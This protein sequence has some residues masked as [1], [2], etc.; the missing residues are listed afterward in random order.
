MF[1]NH[2][3]I[4]WRSLLKN[5]ITGFINI[6]GLAIGMAVAMMIGL[7]LHDELTFDQY[8]ENYEKLGQV[9]LHQEFNES[10]VTGQAASMPWGASLRN[11]FTEDFEN[12]SM[13]SWLWEHL[14]VHGENRFLKEGHYV[15]PEFPEM[16]SL[17][18]LAGNRKDALQEPKS[19]ILSKSLSVA[20]FGE[21]DPMGKM[22]K[23]DNSIDSWGNHSFQLFV[24]LKENANFADVTEKIR[25]LER[26]H[27]PVGN[28]EAMIHPIADWHL[29]SEFKEGV[30]IGGRIQF[31][32][33]FGIIGVFVLLLACINF[34]NLSTARSEKRSKE[35]GVRKAIGSLRSQLIAQF[36]SESLMVSGLALTLALVLVQGSMTAFNNLADKELAI[37]MTNV[38]FWLLVFG[39]TIFTGFLAGSYPAFYLSSFKPINT[40]KG[41]F[42]VGKWASAPRKVLVTLQFVVSIALIIGT[43]VVFQQIEYAK[44]R[45]IGYERDSLIQFFN[46]RELHDQRAIIR[47]EM[48]KTGVVEEL[49]H[50]SGPITNIWSNQSS[51]EW[52]GKDPNVELSFGVVGVSH[53]FGE[54]IQWDILE[55]RDFSREFA[56]DSMSIILNESAVALMDLDNPAGKNVRWNDRNCQVVGVVKDM[57]MESPYE[58]IKPTIFGV[59]NNRISI[60]T[61]RLKPGVPV[62]TALAKIREV[63]ANLCPTN[64]FDYEFVDAAFDEKFRSEERIGQLARIFAFLAIFISCLGLFGLSAFVAEQ[65]TK[66]IGIRK[67]LGASVMNLW[68]LQSKSFLVLVFLSCF[69]AIPLAWYYLENWLADYEYRIE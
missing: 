44:N 18:M 31:L 16:F 11:D 3:K 49:A 37:P 60:F 20:L 59:D 54:T 4:A 6:V 51:V 15:E 42:K 41:T 2:L 61:A 69:V 55:G 64:P 21:E 7:W 66:E 29:K 23:F 9:L 39:F 12:I 32:W 24:Q 19:I 45:S 25:Y 22:V 48:I 43:I 53:E 10:I 33:L 40:L 30:N 13:C 38:T 8:H 1:Q 67:V 57:I 63:Y 36:L 35:V 14:L 17:K 34:M 26:E 65:R 58:P 62:Q 27:N 47:D 50:S 68:V 28:P 46:N 52:E 56:T 5:K